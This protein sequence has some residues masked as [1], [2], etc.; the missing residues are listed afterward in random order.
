[1]TSPAR[2]R[3]GNRGAE[4]ASFLARRRHRDQQ[5]A[6]RGMTTLLDLFEDAARG[7]GRIRFLPD[8]PEGRS[9]QELWRS[10]QAAAGWLRARV[11]DGG[12]VGAVLSS[13]FDCLVSMVGAWQAGLTLC[14]LPHRAR[15]T[16]VDEY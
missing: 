16:P 11:G 9:V 7:V 1:M 13:S 4:N 10:S 15:G 8:D 12:A 2:R 5:R 3:G 6:S 14:S